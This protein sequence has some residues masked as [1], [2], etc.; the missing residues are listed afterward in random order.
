MNSSIKSFYIM[1]MTGLMFF[2]FCTSD[3]CEITR[4]KITKTPVY[5]S[6]D[7]IRK[8]VTAAPPQELKNPGKIYYLPPYIFI[9]EIKKGIHVIDNQ[10]PT[11]PKPKAF[12]NIPGNVD[13]VTKGNIL[14]ADSYCDLVTLDISNPDNVVEKSRLKKVFTEALSGIPDTS[15][16]IFIKYETKVEE[17]TETVDCA[18]ATPIKNTT[19]Y[20]E[21]FVM[22]VPNSFVA[23][24]GSQNV[25]GKS[26]SLARFVT[27]GNYLYGLNRN[28]V[29]LFNL[30]NPSIPALESRLIVNW[31]A[32]TLFPYKNNILIGT[33]SGMLVYDISNPGNPSYV[34]QFNH[35][36]S[37]DPVVALDT[38]AYVTLRDGS[39]CRGGK[40]ELNIINLADINKPV[41]L[42]TYLMANPHGLGVNDTLLFVCE[43]NYGLKVLNIKKPNSVSIIEFFTNISTYDVIPLD[44]NW[45]VIG[46]DGLFQYDA[47]DPHNLK[48]LSK[49][50]VVK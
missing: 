42:S 48:L 36:F 40:N 8:P 24:G 50:P 43:G 18:E 47:S 17:I 49:I 16:G 10:D 14:Y 29:L 20:E 13:V 46:K 37:C 22:F 6:W 4:K 9:N 44:D 31:G 21:D 23:A 34:S 45:L 32:E 39:N 7:T 11:H 38:L 5:L 3:K 27:I 41:L 30:S 26:G 12:Y 19:S 15:K 33:T 2:Q 28:E 35:I 1:G 25:V